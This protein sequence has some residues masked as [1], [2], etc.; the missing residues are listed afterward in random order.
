MPRLPTT[1]RSSLYPQ[2]GAGTPAAVCSAAGSRD[3]LGIGTGQKSAKAMA[4]LIAAGD[5]TVNEYSGGPAKDAASTRERHPVW[6][7]GA[8]GSMRT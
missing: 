4:G 5:A 1:A 6:W 3:Y 2:R 8:P 7:R